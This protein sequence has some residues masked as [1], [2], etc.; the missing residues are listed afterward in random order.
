MSA[1]GALYLFPADGV[2]GVETR[3]AAPRGTPGPAPGN[4][5][6]DSE[7]NNGG[8]TQPRNEAWKDILF[9]KSHYTT[10]NSNPGPSYLRR[11]SGAFGQNRVQNGNNKTFI[12][13]IDRIL[14]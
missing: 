2:T 1:P 7:S 11:V 10:Y 6:P 12:E 13:L 8:G 9:I 14:L 3:P 5:S 4:S